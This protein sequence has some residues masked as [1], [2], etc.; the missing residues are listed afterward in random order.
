MKSKNKVCPLSWT[1]P[2]P[3]D[4]ADTILPNG[5]VASDTKNLLFY[6]RKDHTGRFMMGGRGPL[7]GVANQH[8]TRDRKLHTYPRCANLAPAY[9]ENQ[10]LAALSTEK[11]ICRCRRNLVSHDGR[12]HGLVISKMLHLIL[13]SE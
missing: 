3:Q 7:R 9:I 13:A 11:N 1:E 10:V 12:R 2:L 5:H 8:G 6:F 4:I